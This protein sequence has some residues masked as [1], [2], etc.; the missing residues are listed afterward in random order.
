LQKWKEKIGDYIALGAKHEGWLK[1]AD[2]AAAIGLAWG[3]MGEW[4]EAIPPL[5]TAIKAEKSNCPLRVLE[6]CANFK[7]R[8]AAKQFS[9][10]APADRDRN[11]N[12]YVVI[13]E[14][15]I[16]DLKILSGFA[17]TEE[18]LSLIGGSYKRLA[19]VQTEPS[20]RDRAKQEMANYYEKAYEKRQKAYA[21]TNWATAFMLVDPA[22]AKKKNFE[23]VAVSLKD[24]LTTDLVNEQNF[25]N[26][27]GIA[28]IDLVRFINA[29]LPAT[30][31]AL[32][33]K[34]AE[35]KNEIIKGYRRAI[36]RGVSPREKGSVIENLDFVIEMIKNPDDPI[37][38]AVQEIRDSL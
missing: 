2:V 34:A 33:E 17:E 16:D 24:A 21:F 15:A 26:F 35:L 23:T 20:G 38:K 36:N 31:A 28:D 12:E 5:E 19:L 6:Q 13:I 32:N 4:A 18:R 8:L 10:C 11:R 30:P 3:E 9:E 22:A 7:V 14:R 29:S 25:W 37:R 27:A 1:R